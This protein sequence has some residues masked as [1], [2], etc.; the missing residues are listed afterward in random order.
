MTEPSGPG[1]VVSFWPAWTRSLDTMI[2]SLARARSRCRQ[3]RISLHVDLDA[4]RMW[5]G[6]SASLIDR[7]DACAV[8]GCGGTVYYL[9]APATGA[10]YHVL[11]DRQAPLDGICDPVG[12]PF[13]SRWHG[14][15]AIGPVPDPAP[16]ADIVGL[17]DD[18][19]ESSRSPE[20]TA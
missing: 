20:M 9:G 4:M 1:H 19:A 2:G 10:S 12:R 5:L 6:G 11:I 16:V 18:V 13:R 15:V 17:H 7:S 8:V 3:C 14:M